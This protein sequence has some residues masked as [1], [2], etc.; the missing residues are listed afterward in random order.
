MANDIHSIY[1]GLFVVSEFSYVFN[2]AQMLAIGSESQ[3]AV[4]PYI[5]RDT[6]NLEQTKA[7]AEDI[8]QSRRLFYVDCVTLDV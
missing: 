7:L 6:I 2:Q 8:C 3:E 4:P 1:N 5:K